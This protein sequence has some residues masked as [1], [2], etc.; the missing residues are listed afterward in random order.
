[1]EVSAVEIFDGSNFQCWLMRIRW[2]LARHSLEHMMSSS[3]LEA[4]YLAASSQVRTKEKFTG[5]REENS[6]A[7]YVVTTRIS[8]KV[9]YRVLGSETV[10]QL[11]ESLKRLYCVRSEVGLDMARKRLMTLQY[12]ENGD[13]KQYIEK[14]ELF[15]QQYRE[16]G[17]RFDEYEE[18][19]QF[20]MSL[21]A[22]Y[23]DVRNWYSLAHAEDRN[24]ENLK[25][26]AIDHYEYVIR[27]QTRKDRYA[28]F[29]NNGNSSNRRDNDSDRIFRNIKCYECGELGHMARDCNRRGYVFL[30]ALPGSILMRLEDK[31]VRLS[32]T[33]GLFNVF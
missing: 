10:A 24:L 9:L 26:R 8:S 18:I 16:M 2:L 3:K 31:L 20:R 1:M 15:V 28:L 19:E 5:F 14:F 22:S 29:N 32:W 25:R 7:M 6:K 33:I 13:L 4:E 21:P 23:G 12:N 11:I 17:G 27:D 30:V